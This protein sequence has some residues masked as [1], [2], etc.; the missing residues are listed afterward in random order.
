VSAALAGCGAR[1][2]CQCAASR[3]SCDQGAVIPMAMADMCDVT[4]ATAEQ[5]AAAAG[6]NLWQSATHPM[7][8]KKQFPFDYA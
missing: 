3:S 4:A 1:G 5:K 8:A 2:C 7:D 6:W